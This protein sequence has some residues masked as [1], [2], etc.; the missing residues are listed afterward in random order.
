MHCVQFKCTKASEEDPLHDW[1]FLCRHDK[2]EPATYLWRQ[3]AF[4]V[5]ILFWETEHYWNLLCKLNIKTVLGIGGWV[6][7]KKFH[8]SNCVRTI[9]CGHGRF[10]FIGGNN[11]LLVSSYW[12]STCNRSK[13]L[14]GTVS[15]ILV[16]KMKKFV[17]II[18]SVCRWF[19][20][21]CRN[22]FAPAC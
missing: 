19:Q 8:H 12:S 14:R 22:D 13:N 5:G 6:F 3:H 16:E 2:R 15:L 4:Y 7:A 9:Q 11:C 20:E 18:A 1:I 21:I 10:H 17:E